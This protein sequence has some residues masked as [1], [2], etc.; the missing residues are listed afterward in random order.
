MVGR[1][2]VLQPAMGSYRQQFLE[3]LASVSDLIFLVGDAHFVTTVRTGV[4][5]PLIRS[6]G[7]NRYI[8]GR[9]LGWQRGVWLE[10]VRASVLVAELNPRNLNTWGL[11]LA[12]KLLGRRTV[13][14]GHAWPRAGA[15]SSTDLLRGV[16]RRLADRLLVYTHEQRRSLLTKQPQ[17][18]ISVAPNSLY[19]K[20]DMYS[21]E[22]AEGEDP[23]FIWI[24]RLVPDKRLTLALE[25]LAHFNSSAGRRATLIVIGDG[26]ERDACQRRAVQLGVDAYVT[27]LGWQD[28]VNYLRS[29][30][31][32]ATSCI[33]SGYVGLNATQSLGFGCPVIWSR[34]P[35]NAPEAA[36]LG[37]EN[38]VLFAANDAVD[39]SCAMA[40]A[41]SRQFDRHEIARHTAENY[42]VEA[43]AEGFLECLK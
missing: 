23:R 1:R 40:L 17:L 33:S 5:S 37:A 34:S 8:L 29:M 15:S 36:L 14:W 32:E 42:S 20:K 27:F 43:M 31:H 6:T 18:A 38:S 11:L 7:N 24:G 12:R 9:R 28:D 22:L 41:V 16:L 10:S 13:L 19:W 26:P 25:G 4:R 2:V 35:S 21:A 3:A 30:F 39:L